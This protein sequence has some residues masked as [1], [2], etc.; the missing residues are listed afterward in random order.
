M[1]MVKT[2]STRGNEIKL[3]NKQ[4]VHG[5]HGWH[6]HLRSCREKKSSSLEIYSAYFLSI[7][8]Y[9]SYLMLPNMQRGIL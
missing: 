1:Y 2:K 3:Y 5:G 7:S 4:C 6:L 9:C 8:F